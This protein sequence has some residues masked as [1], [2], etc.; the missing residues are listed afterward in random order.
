M[1]SFE[2]VV[3]NPSF[4]V[5]DNFRRDEAEPGPAYDVAL[6]TLESQDLCQP[7]LAA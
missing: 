3:V 5:D 6:R 2:A 1:R 4:E 7:H